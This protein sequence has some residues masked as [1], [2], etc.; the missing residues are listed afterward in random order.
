MEVL[1]MSSLLRTM[2]KPQR[3]RWD[4]GA[5]ASS[6]STPPTSTRS[7]EQLPYPRRSIG[8]L[9]LGG[10]LWRTGIETQARTW[11]LPI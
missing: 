7:I 8:V 6:S 10:I 5:A 2:D 9:E 3:E 11:A 4:L 1:L